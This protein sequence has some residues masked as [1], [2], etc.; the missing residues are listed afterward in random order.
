VEDLGVVDPAFMFWV[1]PDNRIAIRQ[2]TE[3]KRRR[4]GNG[5]KQDPLALR[6]N[7]FGWSLIGF[8]YIWTSPDQPGQKQLVCRPLMPFSFRELYR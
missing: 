1:Q 3:T 8:E 2:L 4:P 5:F 6:L 7:K